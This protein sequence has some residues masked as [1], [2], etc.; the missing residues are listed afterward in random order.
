MRQIVMFGQDDLNQF[1]EEAAE[2]LPFVG[3]R[4]SFGLTKL[5]TWPI[6]SRMTSG[7]RLSCGGWVI[8]CRPRGVVG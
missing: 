1:G 3:A 5:Q 4:V 8:G 7:S 6:E 2:S